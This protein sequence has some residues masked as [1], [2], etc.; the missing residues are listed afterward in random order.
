MTVDEVFFEQT[1]FRVVPSLCILVQEVLKYHT[2]RN[3]LLVYAMQF[4]MKQPAAQPELSRVASKLGEV[5]KVVVVLVRHLNK[6]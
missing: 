1:E 4:S 2:S 3:G 6:K 5:V